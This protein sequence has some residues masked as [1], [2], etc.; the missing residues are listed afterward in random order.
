[1]AK[2]K[3]VKQ[4]TGKIESLTPEQEA[5]LDVYRDKWI[6]IGLSTERV[7]REVAMESVRKLYE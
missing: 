3:Q 6:K 4:P 5:Q 1:M 7:D 2:A